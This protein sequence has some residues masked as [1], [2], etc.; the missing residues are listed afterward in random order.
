MQRT[1]AL[2]RQAVEAPNTVCTE[3]ARFYT[4]TYRAHPQEPVIIRRALALQRTLRHMSVRIDPGELVVG[5]H[6]T[7]LRAA[8]IFPEYSVDWLLAELDELEN[9]P[10]DVFHVSAEQKRSI[11]EICQFWVGQTVCDRAY[12]LMPPLTR[13]IHEWTSAGRLLEPLLPGRTDRRGDRHRRRSF[14]RLHRRSR[15]SAW[16]SI[17][18][19]AWCRIRRIEGT[20]PG[21][22]P[23]KSAG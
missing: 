17:T 20:W 8:P 5:N 21:R 7:A 11:R 19:R 6:S 3:R 13:E 18:G 12:A 16:R 14:P 22:R 1:A 9:R 10:G 2:K 15:R 23:R 4:E